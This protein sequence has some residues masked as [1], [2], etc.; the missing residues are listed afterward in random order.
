MMDNTLYIIKINIEIKK[1]ICKRYLPLLTHSQNKTKRT[2]S[3]ENLQVEEINNA[4]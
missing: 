1:K 3:K 2:G 4:N